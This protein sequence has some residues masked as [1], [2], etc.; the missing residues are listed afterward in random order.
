MKVYVV[1][2]IGWEYNDE[3]YYRPEDEDGIPKVAYESKEEAHAVCAEA[4]ARKL[5]SPNGKA[6]VKECD[7]EY[8]EEQITEFFEVKMVE[9][10]HHLHLLAG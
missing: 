10:I 1:M 5:D 8:G 2:E 7:S 9:L 6:M 3:N 4:N